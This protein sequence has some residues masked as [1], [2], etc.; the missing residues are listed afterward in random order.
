[1]NDYVKNLEERVDKLQEMI[2]NV[3][4]NKEQEDGLV[5][6]FVPVEGKTFC[7]GVGDID[8]K[9]NQVVFDSLKQCFLHCMKTCQHGGGYATFDN[10]K[11]IYNTLYS[12]ISLFKIY[13]MSIYTLD[14]TLVFPTKI[15]IEKIQKLY[16][17]HGGS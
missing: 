15:Q 8:S 14:K 1:M 10:E 3:S 7:L 2:F 17:L 16:E 9:R 12:F 4:N 11:F 6:Y 5:Y 13:S